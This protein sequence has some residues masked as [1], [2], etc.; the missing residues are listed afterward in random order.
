M[1]IDVRSSRAARRMFVAARQNRTCA[2]R[3]RDIHETFCTRR[4]A[5]RTN[6]SALWIVGHK[7]QANEDSDRAA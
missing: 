5:T 2:R 3:T 7:H 4:G 1:T 6:I